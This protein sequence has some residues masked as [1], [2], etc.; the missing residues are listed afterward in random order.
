MQT[1]PPNQTTTS[2]S[3]RKTYFNKGL[4]RLL[5]MTHSVCWRKAKV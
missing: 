4:G 1:K 5:N 2:S 3:V